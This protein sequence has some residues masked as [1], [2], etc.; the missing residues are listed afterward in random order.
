MPIVTLEQ[1][2]EGNRFLESII[3]ESNTSYQ[4]ETL[5]LIFKR[6]REI[7]GIHDIL[8]IKEIGR[9]DKWPVADTFW[10][11][12]T[13]DPRQFRDRW[14]PE[15]YE[16]NLPCDYVTF[17]RKDDRTTESMDIPDGMVAI[18]MQYYNVN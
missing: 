1:F 17:P 16:N 15:F 4:P 18:G 3:G 14:P 7:D 9:A 13:A 5:Y 12:A 8:E 11:V 10:V 2:F 6:L